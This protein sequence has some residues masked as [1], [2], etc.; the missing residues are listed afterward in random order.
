M[1]AGG[2]RVP[3]AARFQVGGKRNTEHEEDAAITDRSRSTALDTHSANLAYNILHKTMRKRVAAGGL[4][5]STALV[6][7]LPVHHHR[8]PFP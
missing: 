5:G 6:L 2:G 1:C 8:D 3:R 7:H 4:G